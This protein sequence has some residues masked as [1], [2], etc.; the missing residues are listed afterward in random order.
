MAELLN[1]DSVRMSILPGGAKR[2]RLIDNDRVSGSKCVFDRL[3]LDSDATFDVNI[4]KTDIIWA[5]LLKGSAVLHSEHQEWAL[6]ESHIFFLQPGFSGTLSTSTG[7]VFILLKVS[8]A[9]D[10]DSTLATTSS[11]AQFFDLGAEPVLES[12]HDERTR[13]YV[14]TNQLFGTTALAG[15]LVI[16]PV[17]SMS[18]NHHHTGA[19][20]FQY[21]LRGEGTLF[22]NEVPHSLK[23]GD[24]VYKY[25]GERHYCHNNG[26]EEFAFVEFFVPGKWETVW[27][28]PERSCTWSPT[29]QNLR[30]GIASREIT[31]HTSDGTIYDD[32]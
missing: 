13:V 20:H 18:A 15:E 1:H 32:V 10:F 2:Q 23:S 30:G 11:D 25:D 9:L 28:D 29:G 3:T 24:L 27:A 19:E 6:A 14:A 26:E 16:F 8:N 21:I 31:A 22:L 12:K 5:Q 4:S 7:A 17:G